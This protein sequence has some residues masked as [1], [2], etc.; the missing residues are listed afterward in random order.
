VVK[1][2]LRVIE[3]EGYTAERFIWIHT[4]AEENF[5]LHMEIAARGT[6]LEYDS[7]GSDW[8]SDGIMI[9][10]ITR[11]LDV[12]FDNQ[13]ML[14]HDRG[15]FDPSQ[16]GGGEPKPYTYLSEN[17]LPRLRE[18]GI[19]ETTIQQLTHSNPFKAFAR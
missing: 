12:G 9:D 3:D 18:V 17:F 7:I 13:I 6:L 11:L 10:N 16:P 1:D 2:Q 19:D 14:S 4:Q 8:T 5:E 15:W